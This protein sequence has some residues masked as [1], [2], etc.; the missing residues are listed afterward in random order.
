MRLLIATDAWRPQINGVVRTV[1]RMCEQLPDLAGSGFVVPRLQDRAVRGVSYSSRKWAG[2]VPGPGHTLVRVFLRPGGDTSDPVGT[3]RA[4]L[5]DLLG[6]SATPDRVWV[7]EI[8]GGLHSY[9]VGHLDRI[10]AVERALEA[11]PG[12]ALAGA[13]FHGVG[14]NEVVQSGWSAADRVLASLGSLT[15]VEGAGR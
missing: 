14:L 1:E 5:A 12:V 6:V 7:N 2:R 13:G 3:A 10:A 4:E 8:A 9:T 11:R 15:Q